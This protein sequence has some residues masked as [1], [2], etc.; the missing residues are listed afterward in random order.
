MLNAAW[1][2]VGID[3]Q[4][5]AGIYSYAVEE[6]GKLVVLLNTP[7]INSKY[8]INYANEFTC[9]SLKFKLAIDYLQKN[10]S[11]VLELL[12]GSFSSQRIASTSFSIRSLVANLEARQSIFYSDFKSEGSISAIPPVESELLRGAIDELKVVTNKLFIS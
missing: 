9:H 7:L 12:E 11:E 5:S 2:M 4:I 8:R 10:Y 3:E 1:S 6:F